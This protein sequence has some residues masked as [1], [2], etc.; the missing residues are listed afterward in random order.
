VERSD[1]EFAFQYGNERILFEL[2]RVPSARQRISIHV[3]PNGS[4]RVDAPESAAVE[5]VLAAVRK[6]ARWIWIRLQTHHEQGLHVLP[7]EYVSG[8]SHF[9]LGRRHVL[10]VFRDE[11][12]PAGVKLLRGELAITAPSNE[13]KRIRSL[14]EAWYRRRAQEVFGRRLAEL[15][16]AA[17]WLDEA[18]PFR[19]LVM[20]TQWGSCSPAG[21]LLLNP[22]LVK[23]PRPCVDYVLAHEL[24]HLR[25]HNHSPAFYRLLSALLP[26]WP[27]RKEE[28]DRM[29]EMLL[30]R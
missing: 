11:D 9:Y 10:K 27:A 4:V 16:S 2:N 14:L 30:N 1:L 26:D 23:A 29:A 8:E 18:P 24:C 6:R 21:E 5:V 20:R 13:P 25:E 19:L 28:L 7:R 22:H 12:A 17:P 3:L 15:V